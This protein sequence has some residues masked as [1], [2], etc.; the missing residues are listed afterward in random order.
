MRR[1][2]T[3]LPLLHTRSKVPRLTTEG[4]TLFGG[5]ATRNRVR[6]TPEQLDRYIARASLVLTEDQSVSLDASGVVLVDFDRAIVGNGF[7]RA[8]DRSL[9]SYFPKK[10]L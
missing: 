9:E 7:Y 2:H 10:W 4:A 5:R 3:G 8:A 1:R 6:L